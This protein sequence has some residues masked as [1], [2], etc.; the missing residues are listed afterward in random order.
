[1]RRLLACWLMI[2]IVATAEAQPQTSVGTVAGV[3]GA[4][5]IQHDGAWSPAALGA[6]VSV[7][8]VLRTGGSG[9]LRVVFDAHSVLLV[10]PNS[11][12]SVE[13]MSLQPLRAQLNLRRGKVRALV[14]DGFATPGASYEISTAGAVATVRGTD[15]IIVFDPVAEVQATAAGSGRTDVVGVDGRTEVHSVIDRIDHGVFVTSQERVIVER[16]NLPAPPQRLEEVVFKQYLEGLDFIGGPRSASA[17][18]NSPLATGEAVLG[19]KRADNVAG[20]SSGPA[21]ALGHPVAPGETSGAVLSSD[22]LPPVIK[23]PPR[24]S[25]LSG[26]DLN[27]DF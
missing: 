8:D 21:I 20:A 13:Q 19:G 22:L 16:G 9:R 7:S 4:V 23:Q 11:E 25:V 5:E 1:M 17:A 27:V 14:G 10:A 24:A 12:L 15:F 3:D 6:V 2:G 18:Q 26:G